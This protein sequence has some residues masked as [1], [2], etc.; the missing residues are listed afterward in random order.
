MKK[1]LEKSSTS[2][3]VSAGTLVQDIEE[4][5]SKLGDISN[6]SSNGWLK[7]NPASPSDV[8]LATIFTAFVD[9]VMDGQEVTRRNREREVLEIAT[10]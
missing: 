10:I 3:T 6:S 1:E 4:A 9:L 7:P 2:P 8:A 5:L